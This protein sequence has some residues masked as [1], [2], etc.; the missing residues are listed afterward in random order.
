MPNDTEQDK[1]ELEFLVSKCFISG[2]GNRLRE[3]ISDVGYFFQPPTLK[4]IESFARQGIFLSDKSED[5]RNTAYQNFFLL[6]ST[7]EQL[8]W[9][10]LT[11]PNGAPRKNIYLPFADSKVILLED[12]P[13][14][15]SETLFDTRIQPPEHDKLKEYM[16][17]VRTNS[18]SIENTI[19]GLRER[20][21]EVT[22]Q[23]APRFLPAFEIHQNRD[24]YDGVLY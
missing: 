13:G 21:I 12:M 15:L 6:S 17:K 19:R 8:P 2:F 24:K 1:Q 18:Q 11:E 16:E 20:I 22:G 7:Y 10:E 5:Y 14:L 23:E 3:L 4:D 9:E